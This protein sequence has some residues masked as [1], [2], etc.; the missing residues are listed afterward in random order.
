MNI[1]LTMYHF[2]EVNCFVHKIGI[3][4][5]LYLLNYISLFL[6]KGPVFTRTPFCFNEHNLNIKMTIIHCEISFNKTRIKP[7]TYVFII[8]NKLAMTN[9]N[10]Y[11]Y[12]CNFFSIKIS[13]CKN[14]FAGSRIA[15]SK[16]MF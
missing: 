4:I 9:A 12:G 15:P 14:C 2:G 8:S 1:L 5:V 13:Y 6:H 3:S 16:Y 7:R 10:M 11:T